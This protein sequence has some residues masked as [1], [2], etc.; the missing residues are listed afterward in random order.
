MNAEQHNAFAIRILKVDA[1]VNVIIGVLFI[2]IPGLIDDL[3][4]S[5]PLIPFVI[6]RIIGASFILFAIWEG[7]VVR[8]PPLSTA[9]LAFASMM[10]L[11]PVVLLTIALLFGGFPLLL[12]G[13]IILWSGD[14][15]MLLLGSYYAQ[16][17][18][19]ARREQVSAG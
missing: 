3:L 5:A 4:G 1:V 7:I 8:R 10:A 6:W 13:R 18:W 11:V 19:R 14:L 17:I 15:A 12:F 16:V 2:A 9:S